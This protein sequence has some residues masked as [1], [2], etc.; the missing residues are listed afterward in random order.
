[1]AM[2]TT[3]IWRAASYARLS[4]EDGTE[5]KSSS[6]VSQQGIID[7]YSAI[8]DDIEI[9][10]RFVDDG[11]SGC[12]FERPGF[13]CM[14]DAV[15]AGSIDCIIVKDLSRLGRN[16]LD[17]GRYLERTLPEKGVRLI[18][19]NDNFDSLNNGVSLG[20]QGEDALIVPFKNLINDY[21]CASS[22]AK[23]KDAL[24]VRRREGLFV[25]A[26]PP[27]GYLKSREDRNSLE[28]DPVAAPVVEEMF[29]LRAEGMSFSSIAADLNGRGVLSPSALKL[30]R[31]CRQSCGVAES[32]GDA[33]RWHASQVRKML[34]N[35][36]YVGV[37]VQGKSYSPSFRSR[38]RIKLAPSEWVRVPGACPA[39]VSRELFALAH[40]TTGEGRA[41]RS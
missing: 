9:V 34:A 10:E 33:P 1:M 13:K 26:F 21:Y 36:M 37:L 40:G 41:P 38:I 15:D 27:Y 31:G 30:S 25:G 18:A 19:V 20:L 12:T 32:K 22:S 3:K 35:E 28:V 14:M 16:Y 29:R 7:S 6:I 24:S 8:R 4:V 17:T 2:R 5:G 39:L 23:I 11:W